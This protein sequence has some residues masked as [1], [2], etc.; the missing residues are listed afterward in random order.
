VTFKT[1][2]LINNTPDTYERVVSNHF[3]VFT[4]AAT[5]TAATALTTGT[6]AAVVTALT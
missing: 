2:I 3:M 5:T 6:A 4:A 1:I